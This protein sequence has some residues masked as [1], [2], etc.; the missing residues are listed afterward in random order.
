VILSQYRYNP[1]R[2]NLD[3]GDIPYRSQ[4]PLDYSGLRYR[5]LWF[6]PKAALG[7]DSP[8]PPTMGKFSDRFV[9][10]DYQLLEQVTHAAEAQTRTTEALAQ[11]M[12]I[13]K[14]ELDSIKKQL[15]N[16]NLEK[17]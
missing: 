3:F 1:M 9:T 11:E 7:A 4:E 14:Q 13:L 15:S 8:D 6:T 10:V 12:E 17:K 2:T 5:T 16:Q